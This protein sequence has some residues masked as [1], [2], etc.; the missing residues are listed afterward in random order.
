MLP[1]YAI[2]KGSILFCLNKAVNLIT[3]DFGWKSQPH[4]LHK[5]DS[6]SETRVP[7]LTSSSPSNLAHF[8]GIQE[9][10]S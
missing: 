1:T 4:H 10:V 8:D 9:R 7:N 2:M 5:E 6:P 3:L